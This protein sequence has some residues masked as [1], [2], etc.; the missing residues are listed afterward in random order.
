M[1][2]AWPET[3]ASGELASEPE[4]WLAAADSLAGVKKGMLPALCS[5]GGV[6]LAG[7]AEDGGESVAAAAVAP[8]A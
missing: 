8:G 3:L 7:G 4:G 2:R 1:A 6:P 5:Q